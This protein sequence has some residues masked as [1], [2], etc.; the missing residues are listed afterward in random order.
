VLSPGTQIRQYEIIRELGRGGMG[1]VFLARDTQHGRR[2]A[3]KFLTTQEPG[4]AGR[5]LVEARATARCNHENIVVI[6][7]V[8]T[9]QGLAYMVLEYLMTSK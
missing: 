5:S 4:V 7:E 9:Y 8:D 2:V 1:C 6:H 3:M